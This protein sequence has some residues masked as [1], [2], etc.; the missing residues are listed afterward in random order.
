MA[1][2]TLE[3]YA[4][5]HRYVKAALRSRRDHPDAIRVSSHPI[6]GP[7]PFSR[8]LSEI[9]GMLF[10][11]GGAEVNAT[12]VLDDHFNY[13]EDGKSMPVSF[14]DSLPPLGKPFDLPSRTDL[15]NSCLDFILVD[16]E[17][18]ARI[19][20]GV[21]AYVLQ[22]QTEINDQAVDQTF[23]GPASV[24]IHCSE[25]FRVGGQA[26]EPGTYVYHVVG[27]EALADLEIHARNTD[28]L[29]CVVQVGFGKHSETLLV[30][31]GR[32]IVSGEFGVDAA[33]DIWWTLDHIGRYPWTWAYNY[34]RAH[35]HRDTRDAVVMTEKWFRIYWY[36]ARVI[37]CLN[38]L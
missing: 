12:V 37:R 33:P 31:G 17:N 19:H 2:S 4:Y 20:Q 23:L 28:I 10:R 36:A 26:R 22:P 29:K 11:I 25:R 38:E 14:F 15:L 27:S 30:E 3:A 13:R 32:F 24:T 8:T 21:N 1:R 34:V 9:L 6:S 5:V 35:Y 16:K 18:P 7:S